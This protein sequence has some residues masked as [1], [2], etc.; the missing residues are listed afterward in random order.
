MISNAR[1]DLCGAEFDWD[2]EWY[3]L[4]NGDDSW[5]RPTESE[6]LWQMDNAGWWQ[7]EFNCI[8]DE[9]CK[10]LEEHD[11][12]PEDWEDYKDGMASRCATAAS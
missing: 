8:C 2:E 10:E 7:N 9:C 3:V 6:L 11:M 5:R 1:C 12:S 4:P